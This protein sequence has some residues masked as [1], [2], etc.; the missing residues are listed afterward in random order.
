[1]TKKLN[2]VVPTEIGDVTLGQYQDIVRLLR[3]EEA[4]NI[5]AKLFAILTS[6]DE[7]LVLQIKG[8]IVQNTVANITALLNKS[9]Y[10]LIHRFELNGIEF[11]LIPDLEGGMTYGEWMDLD[12][13][14]ADTDNMHRLMAVLFRPILK[15]RNRK[16]TGQYQIAEYIDTK[17]YGEAM[18]LMPVDIAL[19]AMS[20]FVELGR[21]LLSGIPSYLESQIATPQAQASLRN[22]EDGGATILDSI[23]YLKETYA[24]FVKSNVST[25]TKPLPSL[26]TK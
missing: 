25:L 2:I 7:E 10:S 12:T 21:Q 9:K 24:D 26:N 16:L 20:F 18:K 4:N 11:G 17:K 8:D 23:D 1:M 6:I 22:L 3:D 19:G 14:F 13:Y 5:E 15:K